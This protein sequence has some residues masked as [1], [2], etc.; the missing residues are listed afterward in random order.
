MKHLL[1]LLKTLILSMKIVFVFG[2]RFL[3]IYRIQVLGKSFNENF[4]MIFEI[5][6]AKWKYPVCYVQQ[7]GRIYS[8]NNRITARWKALFAMPKSTVVTLVIGWQMIFDNFRAGQPTD[9][10]S[11]RLNKNNQSRVLRILSLVN[12]SLNKYRSRGG[13]YYLILNACANF[14]SELW[15]VKFSKTVY[16]FSNIS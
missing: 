1:S 12:M 7:N 2:R 10:S 11:R 8:C 15:K 4:E 5:I 16:E 9:S 3:Q 14:K 13:G 6:S